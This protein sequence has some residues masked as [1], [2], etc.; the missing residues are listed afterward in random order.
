MQRKISVK[1]EWALSICPLNVL[2]RGSAKYKLIPHLCA[3]DLNCVDEKL[4]SLSNNNVLASGK[5]C[6][7]Y[8][9]SMFSLFWISF[10][11]KYFE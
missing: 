5:C 8:E 6:N 1:V 9:I 3:K 4:G 11:T 7:I 10:T 2:L